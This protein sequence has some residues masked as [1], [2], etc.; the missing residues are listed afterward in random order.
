[1][2]NY[3]ISNI[4][5]IEDLGTTNDYVYDIEMDDTTEHTYFANDILVHNSV[6]LSIQ[7]I[8]NKLNIKLQDEN[9]IVTNEAFQITNDINDLIN[10]KINIWAKEHLNSIDP[11]YEFKKEAICDSA[12]LIRKKRYILHII[13]EGEEK[14][15]PCEKLKPVGV[16]IK[17]SSTPKKIKPFL[18]RLIKKLMLTRSKEET[19][20]EYCQIYEE[21]KNMPVEDIAV[22]VGIKNLEKYAS[23]SNEFKTIKGTPIHVKSAIYYNALLKILN[24]ENKYEK[25]N[26]GEKIKIFYVVPNKYGIES[27]AFNY[28]YPQEFNI[29]MD[30]DKMF[31]RLITKELTRFYDVVKWTLKDP[32]MQKNGN[33]QQ[34]FGF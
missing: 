19:D 20:K 27:I 18:E 25:I 28:Q 23:Q 13:D 33:L 29:K 17:S 6:Y 7:P 21:F 24:I 9:N 16:Q 15:A 12:L 14:Q 31:E 8:L 32:S 26:S 22:S 11:R 10:E 34:I 4:D 2:I 1:M 30:I 5:S 3:Q